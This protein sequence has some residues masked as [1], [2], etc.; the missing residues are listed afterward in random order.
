MPSPSQTDQ[1]IVSTL[2]EVDVPAAPAGLTSRMIYVHSRHNAMKWLAASGVA[3]VAVILVIV[4][5][6]HPST[7]LAQ[8]AAAQSEQ[9]EYT[10]VNTR[11]L[12]NGKELEIVE[13]KDGKR[14]SRRAKTLE[15]TKSGIKEEE[16]PVSGV[17]G[18][19]VM[20]GKQTTIIIHNPPTMDMVEIDDPRPLRD[21]YSFDIHQILRSHGK[22]TKSMGQ[23]WQGRR[24]DRFVFHGLYRD[25][26]KMK[27]VDQTV[28]ADADTHLPLRVEEMR[29]DKSW[30]D[31]WDYQYRQPAE[32]AFEVSIAPTAKVYDL[33][34]ERVAIVRALKTGAVFVNVGQTAHVLI[35]ASN[36]RARPVLP[37]K[38]AGSTARLQAN[39]LIRPKLDI[40]EATKIFVNGKAWEMATFVG[41]PSD[42]AKNFK[43][44][45]GDLVSLN[46]G[47]H[48]LVDV[49]V[50][51]VAN[52]WTLL[53]PYVR[54]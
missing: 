38:V 1:W 30:G 16:P 50:F 36:D 34:K 43:P 44:F 23:T 27:T 46:I 6:L 24:V 49:P 12:G 52:A 47:E 28:I 48:H 41:F 2:R 33:P 32:S 37:V 17:L 19:T 22:L 39:L 3:S 29:D 40:P 11:I 20:D 9:T 31:I 51:H 35:P 8:V 7:S 5:T 10:L 4:G 21:S 14:W 18:V 45:Q 26:G 15:V 13:C 25:S 42:D 53:R 54:D